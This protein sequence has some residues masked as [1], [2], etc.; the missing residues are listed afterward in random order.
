QL[1]GI[2]LLGLFF[3]FFLLLLLLFLLLFG[4]EILRY[5]LFKN[6]F[7][8][9]LPENKAKRFKASFPIVKIKIKIE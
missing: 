4:H 6:L 5:Q 8:S 9:S 2:D 7:Y 1:L 3:L